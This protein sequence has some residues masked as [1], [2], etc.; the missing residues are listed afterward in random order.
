MAFFEVFENDI[1]G[2]IPEDIF[3]ICFPSNS[4]NL[5]RNH[6]VGCILARISNLKAL[7]VLMYLIMTYLV[8][9][10]ENLVFALVLKRF[11]WPETLFTDPFLH[12]SELQKVFE[13]LIFCRIIWLAKFQKFIEALSLNILTY[14]P[15][16]S[17][18]N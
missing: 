11:I 17:R 8:K 13:R 10:Q 18:E 1:I 12:F 3:N 14:P 16:I 5:V 6:F 9:F 7:R 4:L 15:M 2:T